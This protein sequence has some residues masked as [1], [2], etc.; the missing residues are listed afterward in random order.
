MEVMGRKCKQVGDGRWMM[1]YKWLE[2]CGG[3]KGEEKKLGLGL[4]LL[5]WAWKVWALTNHGFES[6]WL[7]KSELD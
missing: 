7:G 2:K 6:N 3:L 5:C 4:G 1:G